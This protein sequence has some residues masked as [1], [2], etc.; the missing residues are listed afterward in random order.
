M[1]TASGADGTYR[2]EN[3]KNIA[4]SV[5]P[6]RLAPVEAAAITAYDA[7][8]ALQHA[9]GLATLTGNAAKAADVNLSGGI[10]SMDAFHILQQASG[11]EAITVPGGGK[12]W[13]FDPQVRNFSALS[14]NQTADFGA[15]LLGDISGN[16]GTSN[17]Q[18]GAASVKTGLA[19]VIDPAANQTTVYLLLQAGTVAVR[20]MDVVLTYAAGRSIVTPVK[21]DPDLASSFNTGTAGVLRASL[22]S[23]EGLKG[24]RVLLAV[25]FSGTTSPQVSVQSLVLDEGQILSVGD[26]DPVAFDRDG[27]G[28]VDPLGT[29][30]IKTHPSSATVAV[31]AATSLSV[32]VA[33]NPAPTFQW[34]KDNQLIGGANGASYPI[35]NAQAGDAGSYKVVVSNAA[36]SVTSNSAEVKVSGELLVATHVV[37]GAR[38]P[39]SSSVTVTNSLSYAGSAASAAWQVLLPSG[40]Q[41]ASDSATTASQRPEVGREG[42]LE[43][44]WSTVPASP[45]SFSYT[46]T[47]PS[48]LPSGVQLSA[49]VQVV[50]SGATTEAKVLAKPD[51]LHLGTH[52]A[53]TD[54]DFRISLLELTRVIE[55]YNTRSGTTRTGSYSLAATATEDG[56]T[57]DPARSTSAT[58]TFTRYHSG[59][60]NRDGR[61]ALLELTRVIELYNYRSGNT[62]TG[63]Y[64]PQ[65]GTEDGFSTGPQ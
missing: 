41:L 58:V 20:G 5:T 64:K 9:A 44:R 7:S 45:F 17:V 38:L 57:A 25:T 59:D 16:W 8:L 52:S 11:V 32:V 50:P 24:D 10:T 42:V 51:P 35:P 53:D 31:G 60:T 21:A 39:T 56:F 63:Q 12:A 37:S 55:L 19:T 36:G 3:L 2:F 6:A 47:A 30:V 34:F 48:K 40:L 26:A 33:A 27:N 13:Y 62:R 4:Y 18:A 23:A 65:A 14:G 15:I 28:Q 22:A 1:S 46:L 61:I 49:L 43:W 29:P 54:Q